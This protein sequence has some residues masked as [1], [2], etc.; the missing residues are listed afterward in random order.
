MATTSANCARSAGGSTI[1]SLGM[2]RPQRT[3]S[4]RRGGRDSAVRGRPQFEPSRPRARVGWRVR[5]EPYRG[6]EF[7]RRTSL[8]G[9][10]RGGGAGHRGPPHQAPAR[11][12]GTRRGRRPGLRVGRVGGRST[13]AAH[14][15]PRRP[16]K[17]PWRWG[18]IE[19]LAFVVWAMRPSRS[20]RPRPETVTHGRTESICMR[21]SSCRRGTASSSSACAAILCGRRW[22]ETACA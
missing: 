22:R 10:G 15:W 12:P 2:N 4:W 7:P 1:H 16:C 14:V 18:R 13:G 11:S 21:A 5:E 9:P 19:A 3:D 6:A 17:E 8:H 20:R